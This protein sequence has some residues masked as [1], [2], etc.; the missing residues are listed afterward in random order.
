MSK[1]LVESL[2]YI[3]AVWLHLYIC[4]DNIPR[5]MTY[6]HL[7]GAMNG[8]FSTEVCVCVFLLSVY[9]FCTCT[10]LQSNQKYHFFFRESDDPVFYLIINIARQGTQQQWKWVV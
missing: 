10:C 5:N 4:L 2:Y 7:V 9:N 6:T 3:E 8:N 1:E